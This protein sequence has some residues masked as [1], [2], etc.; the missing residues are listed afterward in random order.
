[1]TDD[2]DR[3]LAEL[4][5]AAE[6]LPEEERIAPND[7]PL[8]NFRYDAAQDAFWD[9]EN[10]RLLKSPKAVN[11]SIHP[12]HWQ[13]TVNDKG[14]EKLRKPSDTLADS[15]L[16][17]VVADSTWR[18][19]EPRI[20]RNKMVDNGRMRNAPGLHI[21]NTYVP[22]EPEP[23]PADATHEVWERHLRTLYPTPGA[24]EHVL[25][26]FAHTLQH[27]EVKINHGIV[28]AGEQGIGKDSLLFPIREAVGGPNTSSIAPKDLLERFNPHV[29]SVLLTVDEIGEERTDWAAKS[30]YNRIKTLLAAP[31]DML[32]MENKAVNKTFVKNVVRVVFTTNS[33]DAFRIP[34][35]DRRLFILNSGVTAAEMGEDYFKGLWQALK[36]RG[37]W[38]AVRDWLLDRELSHF[39][40]SAPPPL[41]EDKQEVIRSSLEARRSPI[42]DVFEEMVEHLEGVKPVVLFPA[43]LVA[44]AREAMGPNFDDEEAVFDSLKGKRLRHVLRE[45]GYAM[46]GPP[47]EGGKWRHK[48]FQSRNV[49]I[50]RNV[51]LDKRESFVNDA[52]VNRPLNFTGQT[53]LR[54]IG[55]EKF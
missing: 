22:P 7:V 31:P 28:L 17:Y 50:L 11:A 34:E 18:P 55:N 48:S 13:S 30:L 49:F 40:A 10:L 46:M 26:F 25:D 36:D 9:I 6:S 47:K 33:P 14:E 53:G 37:D 41:T 42:D 27:P 51:E 3:R 5:S 54:A 20:L 39:N 12:R 43:D 21:L 24:A 32:P 38:M 2:I 8:E 29:Q 16:P 4:Q 45:R 19:G 44:F 15:A 52:L 1:M 35:T 23:A